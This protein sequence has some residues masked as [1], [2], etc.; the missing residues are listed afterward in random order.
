VLRASFEPE[1]DSYTAVRQFLWDS[2][3]DHASLE[4]EATVLLAGELAA[5]AS[6]RSRLTFDVSVE[7][8]APCVWVCVEDLSALLPVPIPRTGELGLI[9]RHLLVVETV[10]DR[11]GFELTD[12]GA[13][14][15]FEMCGDR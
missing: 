5:I 2:V 1:P 9:D 13:R 7:V 11:W 4:W 8:S 14:V 3:S 12:A 10:A 15:W 6:V